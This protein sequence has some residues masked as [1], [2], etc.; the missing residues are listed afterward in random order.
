M[1]VNRNCLICGSPPKD[2]NHRYQSTFLAKC[3]K[4]KLVFSRF[5]PSE[6]SL[7]E[8]YSKYSRNVET[9]PLT[10]EVYAKWTNE[11]KA[12]GLRTHLD[13]GCGSGAL[14]RFANENGMQSEGTEINFDVI[15][16]LNS[17]NLPVRDFE[18]IR[19]STR[20]YDII[21]II[22]VLEHVTDPKLILTSL[23]DKLTAHGILYITTPNFNS[24]NR[25]LWKNRWRALW[26]P[27]HINIF[28]TKSIKEILQISGYEIVDVSTSV[29]ILYDIIDQQT[30]KIATG[31]LGIENQRK[32][33]AR[34]PLTRLTKNC[35]N[36]ILK[37]F[38]IGDTLTV[39]AR[40][41]NQQELQIMSD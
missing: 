31:I 36:L 23:R 7:F 24:L 19:R 10:D 18:S 9:S 32:F 27:D 40:K 11:W 28:S 22:E 1:K 13:F 12:S 8:H 16:M 38:S 37:W 6:E 39:I 20:K 21:T 33:F 5:I 34:N 2:L 35:L 26:Y 30:S 3:T 25:Y 14:V 29:H 4:C 15:A 41:S 17:M